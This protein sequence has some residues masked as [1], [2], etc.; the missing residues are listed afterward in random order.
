MKIFK[1]EEFAGMKNPTPGKT[2]KKDL[3]KELNAQSLYGVFGLV[4][5]GDK[6]GAFHYHERGEHIIVIVNGEGVEIVEGAEFPVKAGD[7]LFVPAGE[8]HTI[9]NR[10]DKEL[11]YLGFMTNTT[12]KP[13]KIEVK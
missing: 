11:R 9:V 3:L 7:V 5:P 10:S 13:D 8:K 6:G 4:L 2:Y 12:G 1:N